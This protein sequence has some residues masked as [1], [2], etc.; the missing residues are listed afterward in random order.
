MDSVNAIIDSTLQSWT[1]LFKFVSSTYKL[2]Y[3]DLVSKWVAHI[4]FKS[5]FNVKT[6][7]F[8]VKPVEVKQVE[9]KNVEVIEE[10]CLVVQKNKK[11]CG[12]S[13]KSDGMCSLHLKTKSSKKEVESDNEQEHIKEPEVVES[14][15]SKS[16]KEA[17]P[18]VVE[19]PVKKTKK[20]PETEVVEPKKLKSKKE[21]EPEVVETKK[22]KSKKEAEPEVVE[23]KK[24]KSKKEA[25]PEVVETPV[26]KTKK[27]PE[28]EVVEPKKLKSK[29][30]AE[31]VVE[32]KKSK[33]EPRKLQLKKYNDNMWLH[34]ET[35]FVFS[36]EDKMVVGKLIN[37]KVVDLTGEDIELC[38]KWKF[39]Y[40]EPKKIINNQD[41]PNG[42]SDNE[43]SDLEDSDVSSSEEEDEE[44]SEEEGS[45]SE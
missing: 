3:D 35:S 13:V 26:K 19:T 30:E 44:E 7:G 36:K 15:K 12:K 17:E 45:D 11:V 10:K 5:E 21:A 8:N 2:D 32:N 37:N 14:K 43:D 20:E 39:K 22:S 25:E 4:D 41:K 29:K 1:Q 31:P 24:S 34:E 9:S 40:I 23:N 28:P 27:E 42:E 16:K 33:D 38:N 6:T 18:E